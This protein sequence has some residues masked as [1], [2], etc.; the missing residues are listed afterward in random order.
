LPKVV[1][2]LIEPAQYRGRK[3]LVVGGGDSALEAAARSPMSPTPSQPGVSQRRVHPRPQAEP[4]GGRTPGGRRDGS[5]LLLNTQTQM[6]GEKSVTLG[7]DG[8]E[9]RFPTTT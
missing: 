4:R 9:R 7:R 6:I 3:V 2:R 5:N 8:A 1:Y